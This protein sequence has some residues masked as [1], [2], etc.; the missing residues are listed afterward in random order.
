[1]KE[2]M[3]TA[4]SKVHNDGVNRRNFIAK[5]VLAGAGM[6]ITALPKDGNAKTTEQEKKP[7]GAS[8]PGIRK[9][10][11]LE[12][13]SVGIGPHTQG[14]KANPGL[15]LANAFSVC[16]SKTGG[17]T[18]GLRTIWLSRLIFLC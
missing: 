14:F 16:E 8:K 10:G 12:V 6:A 1:M 2:D 7:A 18:L 5:T 3:K 15:E 11:R 9:L 13:S 4:K 17:L